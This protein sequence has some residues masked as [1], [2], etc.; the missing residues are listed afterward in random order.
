MSQTRGA[1]LQLYDN[2]KKT[3]MTRPPKKPKAK[4]TPKRG[5]PRSRP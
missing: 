3:V 4:P 2:V 5:R 1:H